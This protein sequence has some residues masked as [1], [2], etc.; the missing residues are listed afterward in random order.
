MFVPISPLTLATMASIAVTIVGFMCLFK[1]CRPFNFFKASMFILCV[2]LYALAVI[3]L[4]KL[5][6]PNMYNLFEYVSLSFNEILYLIAVCQAC[7]PIYVV[8]DKLC[9]LSPNTTNNTT[10]E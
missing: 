4:S 1:M 10:K 8:L 3:F 9:N 6:M 2:S 7:Y 5:F